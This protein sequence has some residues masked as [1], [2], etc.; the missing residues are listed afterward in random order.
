[1]SIDIARIKQ[2]NARVTQAKNDIAQSKAELDISQKEVQKLCAELTAELGYSVTPDNVMDVYNN[3]CA[4]VEQTLNNG[5]Q[6][7]N[8]IGQATAES[9]TFGAGQVFGGASQSNVVQN[10]GAGNTGTQAGVQNGGMMGNGIPS[11]AQQNTANGGAN[12][13]GG[14][15]FAS[16]PVGGTSYGANVADQVL[17]GFGFDKFD[18]G[19]G[20]TAQVG[21][22]FGVN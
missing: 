21:N 5:E 10:G 17:G 2:F 18:A 16:N 7:L 15:G 11:M 14:M 8:R 13:N 22:I 20:E 9:Q 4:Q 3:Y 6:I 12:P 19:N 1:M